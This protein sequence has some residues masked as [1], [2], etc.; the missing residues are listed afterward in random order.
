MRITDTV[1]AIVKATSHI[2]T[3][4]IAHVIQTRLCVE[5]FLTSLGVDAAGRKRWGSAFGRKT[6]QIARK[7]GFEPSKERLAVAQGN[8]WTDAFTYPHADF[9]VAALT[10]PDRNGFTYIDKIGISA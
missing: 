8:G 3:W 9:L 5:S 4:L 10:E 2:G 6:A 1:R 7:A